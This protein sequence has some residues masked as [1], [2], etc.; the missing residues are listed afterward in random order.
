[1]ALVVTVLG[2]VLFMGALVAIMTT[3]LSRLMRRLETGLTPIAQRGHILILG[4]TNRTPTI[5]R[6]LL[7]I[8][9]EFDVPFWPIRVMNRKIEPW[10]QEPK[11]QSYAY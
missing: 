2:Y 8:H 10:K 7:A 1:M 4:W 9:K 6:E 5:V 3:A 11:R